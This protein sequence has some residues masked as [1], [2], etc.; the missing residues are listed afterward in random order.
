MAKGEA[1]SSSRTMLFSVIGC[2]L[3]TWASR[4]ALA[5]GALHPYGTGQCLTPQQVV[6]ALH[7]QFPQSYAAISSRFGSPEYRD[8]RSD[9][10]CLPN[11]GGYARF[12]FDR[13][14]RA[15]NLGWSQ[16]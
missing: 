3:G 1:M 10:H 12:D 2:G 7:L 5:V 9:W 13:T 4:A 8:R 6:V 16:F 14:G 15:V 11:G